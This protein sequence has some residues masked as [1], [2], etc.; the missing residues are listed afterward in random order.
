M[1]QLRPSCLA[2]AGHAA[3]LLALDG[4]AHVLQ[5]LLKVAFGFLAVLAVQAVTCFPFAQLSDAQDDDFSTVLFIIV[6]KVGL[7][8]VPDPVAFGGDKRKA[9]SADV[10]Y[11]AGIV[12]AELCS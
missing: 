1:R 2:S 12:G 8:D 7:D 11:R 6:T 9:G 4:H 5:A 3:Q 10:Q